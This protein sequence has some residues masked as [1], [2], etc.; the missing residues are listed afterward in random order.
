MLKLKKRNHQRQLK[1]S[2]HLK[3]S[4]SDITKNC[5]FENI[6]TPFKILIS[7]VN[8]SIDLKTAYV[9]VSPIWL[10]EK[11]LE[12]YEFLEFLRKEAHVFRKKL[13]SYLSMRYTPKIIFKIDT[14]EKD[15]QKI[16]NLFN[17]PKIAQDL[18]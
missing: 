16:E 5:F 8:V 15:S 4:L 13:G 9:F 18:N 17:D 3:R 1:I 7:E 6:D 10:K 12:E 11:K 2:E 14:L